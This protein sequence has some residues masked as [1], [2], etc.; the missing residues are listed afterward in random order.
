MKTRCLTIEEQSCIVGLH[1]AGVK[2][3]EIAAKLGHPKTTVY[4][5][6]K[7]FERHGTLEGQKSTGRPRKLSECSIRVV[8]HALAT[9]CRQTLEDITNRS[10]FDVSTSTIRTALHNVGFHN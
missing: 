8:T 6:L 4:I 3:V 5:V 2:G 10:G 9:N 1:K 7:R